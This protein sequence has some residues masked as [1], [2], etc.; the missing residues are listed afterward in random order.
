MVYTYHYPAG[1]INSQNQVF[2]D[3]SRAEKVFRFPVLFNEVK[4][5]LSAERCYL[6]TKPITDPVRK[7]NLEA[8]IHD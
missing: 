3:I 4:L 1:N 5:L 6:H 7:L 8:S 2:S